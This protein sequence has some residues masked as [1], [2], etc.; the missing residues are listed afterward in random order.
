MVIA[1]SMDIVSE[2]GGNT[3]VGMMTYAGEGPIAFRAILNA[4]E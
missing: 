4:G 1:V 3:L 2:D